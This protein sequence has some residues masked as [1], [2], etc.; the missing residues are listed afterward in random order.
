MQSKM[1][2]SNIGNNLNFPF[3]R[4]LEH[5]AAEGI[6]VWGISIAN[7]PLYASVNYVPTKINNM[8]WTLDA[9]VLLCIF[10]YT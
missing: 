6:P 4:F 9:M 2:W 3:I 7:E 5:Y 1:S 10:Y 8:G